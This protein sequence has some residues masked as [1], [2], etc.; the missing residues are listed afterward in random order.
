MRREWNCE[1]E[2]RPVSQVGGPG[3]LTRTRRD[4]TAVTETRDKKIPRHGIDDVP[5]APRYAYSLHPSPARSTGATA[6]QRF[7]GCVLVTTSNGGGRSTPA[8][9]GPGE[10][11]TARRSPGTA[12]ATSAAP[13]VA[14]TPMAERRRVPIGA[15]CAPCSCGTPA[16]ADAPLTGWAAETAPGG[17]L[18]VHCGTRGIRRPSG[19][20]CAAGSWRGR[21][22][23]DVVGPP[24]MLTT[25]C[26]YGS[27]APSSSWTTCGRYVAGV[28][29]AALWSRVG[30]GSLVA[31]RR[32]RH[33]PSGEGLFGRS[34]LPHRRW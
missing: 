30:P 22:A 29:C 5:M 16:R 18:L 24:N 6:R 34:P 14:A 25:S 3:G 7:G 27:A 8:T 23:S 10:R 12:T 13:G 2:R 1:T 19:G 33:P 26:Q 28:T 11:P 15:W 31:E 20:P 4:R 17:R 9:S 32:Q 21:R